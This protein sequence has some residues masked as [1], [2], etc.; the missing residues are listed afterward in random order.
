M[1]KSLAQIRESTNT[2]LPRRSQRLCL[3]TG[4]LA[5]MQSLTVELAEVLS[6]SSDPDEPRPPTRLNTPESPRA[7]EIRTR[8]AELDA[9]LG[10]HT[11]ELVIQ[12]VDD[13]EW[14][15]WADNNPPRD[16]G[17]PGYE[18]DLR[19]AYGICNADALKDDLGRY[20][21][22]WNGEPLADGDWDVIRER[23]APGDLKDLCKTVVMMHET[24]VDLPKL[25][26]LWQE[27]MTSV[28]A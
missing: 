24:A 11:G 2:G 21:L 10:E 20:A 8:M 23:A 27:G 9:E 4:L 16:E 19:W 6:R 3:A 13:G 22:T 18:R 7:A 17:Q 1:P 5:E 14:G 15:R 12:G 26:E 25:R 28:N